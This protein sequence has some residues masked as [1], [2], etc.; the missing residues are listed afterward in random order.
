MFDKMQ[1][2]KWRLLAQKDGLQTGGEWKIEVQRKPEG[3]LGPRAGGE[4]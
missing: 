1:R 4:I 3:W 2:S